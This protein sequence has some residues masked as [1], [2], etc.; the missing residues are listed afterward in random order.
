MEWANSHIVLEGHPDWWVCKKCG[1]LIRDPFQHH[2][3]HVALE[4]TAFRGAR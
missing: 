3:F 2:N 1:A 4:V